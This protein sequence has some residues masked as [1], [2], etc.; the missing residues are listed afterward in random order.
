MQFS[1]LGSSRMVVPL[2]SSRC[3]AEG[4]R[5]YFGVGR[6][7]GA[8][9]PRPPPREPGGGSRG[10]LS[11]LHIFHAHFKSPQPPPPCQVKGPHATTARHQRQALSLKNIEPRRNTTFRQD[12]PA[13]PAA[14]RAG[15]AAFEALACGPWRP[16][17]PPKT[18]LPIGKAPRRG[19]EHS[20]SSSPFVANSFGSV[21]PPS[22]HPNKVMDT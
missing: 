1:R 21:P 16:F 13:C 7:L 22:K 5:I 6:G 9:P 10:R 8:P 12:V 15:V 11:F 4:N 19:R 3:L 14:G 18:L 17:P 20:Q 2:P